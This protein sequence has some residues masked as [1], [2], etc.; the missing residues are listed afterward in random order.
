MRSSSVIRL[1]IDRKTQDK[2]DM[3]VLRGAL[4]GLQSSVSSVATNLI[5]AGVAIESSGSIY[6]IPFDNGKTKENGQNI[7][8]SADNINGVLG[9]VGAIIFEIDEKIETLNVELKN[10]LAWEEEQRRLRLI[11]QS[12]KRARERQK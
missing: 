4:S 1:D 7:K 12:K 9:E 2:E 3:M 6:G 8:K 5:N 11:E 10:A